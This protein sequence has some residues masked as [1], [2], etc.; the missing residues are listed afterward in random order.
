MKTTKATELLALLAG[1][2]V[3]TTA[4]AEQPSSMR[5]EKKIILSV[6]DNTPGSPTNADA[7]IR[8]VNRPESNPELAQVLGYPEH[9]T[10]TADL[11]ISPDLADDRWQRL[12]ELAQRYVTLDYSRATDINALET[13]LRHDLRFAYVGKVREGSYSATPNDAFY[14]P[15]SPTPPGP[16][17]TGYHWAYQPSVLNLPQAWDSNTGWTSIGLID[18]GVETAISSK[19]YLYDKNYVLTH[20]DLQ[21]IVA[22][23]HSWNNTSSGGGAPRVTGGFYG[24]HGAHVLG[25]LAANANNAAP[26]SAPNVNVVGG[27]GVCWNCSVNYVVSGMRE[28]NVNDIL[29]PD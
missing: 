27:V 8:A 18:G 4:L 1:L 2:L 19:S 16:P 23:N 21:N 24:T 29:I 6:F 10:K 17:V 5:G 25:I 3:A 20:P 22:I 12:D 9:A 14:S 28:D 7:V 11:A 26:P 15:P 13:R